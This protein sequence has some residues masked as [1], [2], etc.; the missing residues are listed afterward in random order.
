LLALRNTLKD[1]KDFQ[2]HRGKHSSNIFS[3]QQLQSVGQFNIA[4]RQTK[5]LIGDL[6]NGFIIGLLPAFKE[7]LTTLNHWL[8]ANKQLIQMKLHGFVE[9]LAS[10]FKNLTWAISGVF[11]VFNPLVNLIGGWG[12]VLT[13]FIG[14]GI[15][16]WLVRLGAFL[17]T[18]AAAIIFFS[19]AV[20]TLT[21]A[22]M[23]NPLCIA[24]AAI[25][26]AVVLI[27]DEFIVTARGGDSLINR[28]TGLKTVVNNFV[29]VIKVAWEWLV[30]L[31][32]AVYDFTF[33]GGARNM[34]NGMVE[35][36]KETATKISDIFGNM[37]PTFGK[38]SA[39]GMPNLGQ[40]GKY[41]LTP[42]I[43]NR[44]LNLYHQPLGKPG[45]ANVYNT[46]KKTIQ[47][48]VTNVHFNISTPTGG[49]S[50]DNQNMIKLMTKQ[51]E[52]ALDLR[53]AKLLAA[54][55]G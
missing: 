3:P 17:R 14:V 1:A 13:G 47:S 28:F 48:P 46:T 26:A 53:D 50:S 5:R 18:G 20:R 33:G 29:D 42:D 15:L 11:S 38:N 12:T 37:I 27:A 22:L 9:T 4:V 2:S 32:Q 55:G 52:S 45:L 44:N 16:S 40:N 25:A 21:V 43:V 36:A 49:L 54:I 7:H 23:T 41:Q 10:V 30:K 8:I 51:I 39:N 35:D 6:R 24:L 34:F 19:G 31:N